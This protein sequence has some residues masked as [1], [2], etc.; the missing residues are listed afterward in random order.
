MTFTVRLD[1]TLSSALDG[2]FA[3]AGVT[4]SLVVQQSLAAYLLASPLQA[5]PTRDLHT[6]R[7]AASSV[8]DRAFTKAG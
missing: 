3:E 1:A 4:K 2:V 6:E 8:N 5:D 7:A